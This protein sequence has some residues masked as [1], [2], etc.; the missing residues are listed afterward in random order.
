MKNIVAWVLR[1][2]QNSKRMK[3]KDS[4]LLVKE[5]EEAEQIIIK[6]VQ[7]RMLMENPLP[8]KNND[9]SNKRESRKQNKMKLLNLDPYLG[10]RLRRAKEVDVDHHPVMLLK[11]SVVSRKIC[12]HFHQLGQHSGKTSII[13]VIRSAGY[14]VVGVNALVRR[15]LYTCFN[16][17]KL[18]GQLGE[19]VLK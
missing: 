4:S 13:A 16:C 9:G 7:A 15:V 10:G 12:E 8:V 1:F 5:R 18:R 14:W 6:L 11:G 17:R 2:A 19:S 3:N